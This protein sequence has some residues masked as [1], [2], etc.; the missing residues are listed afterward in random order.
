MNRKSV[1]EQNALSAAA[2]MLL[3]SDAKESIVLASCLRGVI[4]H[5]LARA[6]EVIKDAN[7]KVGFI[8]CQI[9]LDEVKKARLAIPSL[10]SKKT[11]ST[12]F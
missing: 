10:N 9:N 5:V 11:Y 6:V 8:N 2:E 3:S 4:L 1:S 12:N 7:E